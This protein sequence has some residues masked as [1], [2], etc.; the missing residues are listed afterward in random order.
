MNRIQKALLTVFGNLGRMHIKGLPRALVVVLMLLLIG[1]ITLYLA[2]W[3]WLWVVRDHVDLPALNGL[4]VTIT[5]VS[6]I[7]AVG[8]IGRALIDDNGDG[9]PDE[10]EKEEKSDEKSNAG[11][12]PDDG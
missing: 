10:F 12:H 8:F 5:S 9:V 2:A 3:I 11:R 4:I 6:F 7:A 1:S